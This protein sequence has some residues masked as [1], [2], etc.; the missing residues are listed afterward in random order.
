[1]TG[2]PIKN[3]YQKKGT[4]MDINN[5]Y[6][7]VE[8]LAEVIAN[9]IEAHIMEDSGNS[10]YDYLNIMDGVHQYAETVAMKTQTMLRDV[11]LDVLGSY[12]FLDDMYKQASKTFDKNQLDR[13]YEMD[14]CEDKPVRRAPTFR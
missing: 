9:H 2:V 6:N 13:Q 10:M 11:E 1:V 4:K 14:A 12:H 7:A 3:K 8:D 5:K